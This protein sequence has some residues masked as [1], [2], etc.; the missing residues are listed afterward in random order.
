MKAI[1]KETKEIFIKDGFGIKIIKGGVYE[2]D[3]RLSI[4][5]DPLFVVYL[6]GDSLKL[7]KC[8]FEKYFDMIS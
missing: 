5:K 7:D 1:A 6:F 8:I 4:T 2:I 3:V